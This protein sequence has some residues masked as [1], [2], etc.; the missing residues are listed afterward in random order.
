MT[1]GRDF[2]V[3]AAAG[4][5]CGCS[6]TTGSVSPFA[7]T[8]AGQP[9]PAEPPAVAYGAFLEGP[10]GAKLSQG[11]RDKALKAEQDALASGQRKTWKGD[12]GVF[13]FVVPRAVAASAPSPVAD[14]TAPVQ[15]AVPPVEACRTFMSTV[16]IAGRP[17]TGHGSGCPNPDG[18][19][20]VTG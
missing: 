9:T 6:L 1:I 3:L 8:A 7:T 19:Y 18:S 13:G 4:L 10:I 2:A 16:F 17:Q 5:L 14:A 15:P 12:N 20:R 11:S